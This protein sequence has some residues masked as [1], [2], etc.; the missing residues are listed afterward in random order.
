MSTGCKKRGIALIPE[1][2]DLMSKKRRAHFWIF[3]LSFNNAP[4][5]SS[6]STYEAR[7]L[8]RMMQ[9]MDKDGILVAEFWTALQPKAEFEQKN[10]AL[11]AETRERVAHRKL[12]LPGDEPSEE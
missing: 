3:R 10:H 8:R 1:Y 2:Q 12:L 4:V 6:S 11:L 7:N 9:F 5:S